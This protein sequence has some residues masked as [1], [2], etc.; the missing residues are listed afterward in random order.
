MPTDFL[1]MFTERQ[2]RFVALLELSRRQPALIEA[3]E[4]TELLS[5]LGTRQR[6][7][8]ELE[9]AA[10]REPDLL[11]RYQSA[12]EHLPGDVRTACESMLSSTEAVLAELVVLDER[13][14]DV[15]AERHA[16]TR[17]EL[18][19]VATASRANAAYSGIDAVAHPRH[20]DFH[21]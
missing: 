12:R 15:L 18:H 1:A 6:L 3:G 21:Q 14:A 17:N 11:T 13:S 20:L 10:D 4:Y 7:L 8:N 5:V 19:G 16:A 2:R 9:T